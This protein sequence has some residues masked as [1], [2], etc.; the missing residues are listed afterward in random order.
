MVGFKGRQGDTD[1]DRRELNDSI[2]FSVE[3]KL[4]LLAKLD[5]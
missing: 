3:R 2:L 4:D 5:A 1:T